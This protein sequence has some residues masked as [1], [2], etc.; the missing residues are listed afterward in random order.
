MALGCA[1]V[2]DENGVINACYER[3]DGSLRAVSEIAECDTQ[4]EI[5]V[6]WNQVGPEG[7]PGP[8]G[9][10]GSGGDVELFY[11]R[12]AGE[13]NVNHTPGPSVPFGTYTEAG[14]PR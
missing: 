11:A 10:A 1:Q 14:G 9:P 13:V 6:S 5:P 7:A 12:E 3:Q 4:V 8:P 2:P